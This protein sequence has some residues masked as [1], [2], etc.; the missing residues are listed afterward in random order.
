MLPLLSFSFLLFQDALVLLLSLLLDESKTR[1]ANLAA[2][3]GLDASNAVNDFHFGR[4][5]VHVR[6]PLALNNNSSRASRKLHFEDVHSR[7][8][9]SPCTLNPD[10]G[11]PV[12]HLAK[13]LLSKLGSDKALD[14]DCRKPHIVKPH[15]A[16]SSSDNLLDSGSCVEEL[17]GAESLDAIEGFPTQKYLG[18]SELQSGNRTSRCKVQ[19]QE[20]FPVL[21][22][23]DTVV[24]HA[25]LFALLFLVR[26]RG[27]LAQLLLLP[28]R[29]RRG[30]NDK[31]FFLLIVG[32]PTFFVSGQ[33][34]CH[35]RRM[36]FGLDLV[37]MVTGLF[38]PSFFFELCKMNIVID[39]PQIQ[40]NLGNQTLEFLTG[41]FVLVHTGGEYG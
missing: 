24:L 19:G 15:T 22:S 8:K 6:P 30:L 18:I 17:F 27:C 9:R 1:P 34:T 2:I 37:K 21:G 20:F 31:I 11:T 38:S 41:A 5:H 23:N 13:L 28:F 39:L 25:R 3:H 36:C 35:C 14:N 26:I 29:H 33:H 12:A 16:L 7:D 40:G 4:P 32:N 10:C